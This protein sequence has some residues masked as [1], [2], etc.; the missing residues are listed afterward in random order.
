M[1]PFSLTWSDLEPLWRWSHIQMNLV[2][3]VIKRKQHNEV[4]T[5]THNCMVVQCIDWWRQRSLE[6]DRCH[7]LFCAI[8]G[9]YSWH[10]F[11]G[12]CT[13]DTLWIAQ[14]NMHTRKLYPAWVWAMMLLC[15]QGVTKR[16]GFQEQFLTM[17][18]IGS[19]LIKRGSR[20]G[21]GGRRIVLYTTI[22][23]FLWKVSSV[24]LQQQVSISRYHVASADARGCGDF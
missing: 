14:H 3:P 4:V 24:H 19:L 12:L 2:E 13:C 7:G 20:G 16:P 10:V 23:L 17:W 11:G 9:S 21:E 22:Y 6:W 8:P 5:T 1:R 15:L 18:C